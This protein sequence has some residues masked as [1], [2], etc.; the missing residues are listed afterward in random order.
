MFLPF[1]DW[2]LKFGVL[3]LGRGVWEPKLVTPII[4]SGIV[5]VA[6][7]CFGLCPLTWFFVSPPLCPFGICG[8]VAE[9]GVFS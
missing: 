4:L 2:E 3:S 7:Q 8:L 9:F 5:I 1:V 6:H